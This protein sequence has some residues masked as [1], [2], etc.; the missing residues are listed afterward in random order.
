MV[1]HYKELQVY[2]KSY[3]AALK[4]HTIT[5]DFSKHEQFALTSQIRRSSKS[6]CANIAEGFA[7]S[8]SSP[9]EFKRFLSI[10]MGSNNE[11]Q[12]W[13]EFCKDLEYIDAEDFA[14]LCPEYEEIGKMLFSLSKNWKT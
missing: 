2:Q 1:S 14:R 5:F 3:Q 8:H 9:A 13:L 4:I 7:K 6:I 10:A 11:V 12:V